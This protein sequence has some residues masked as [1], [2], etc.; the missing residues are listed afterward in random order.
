MRLLEFM[1]RKPII[2]PATIFKMQTLRVGNPEEVTVARE[3]Q[4]L[5]NR[6]RNSS[7]LSAAVEG[8]ESSVKVIE[9]QDMECEVPASQRKV[10]TT[11]FKCL[12]PKWGHFFLSPI[13]K[14]IF[15]VNSEVFS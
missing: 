1:N 6:S 8:L 2:R 4:L 11:K 10:P 5:T 7:T 13:L 9:V 12:F 14:S 15:K 3:L